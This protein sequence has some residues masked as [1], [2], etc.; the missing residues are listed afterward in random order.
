MVNLNW[1][2]VIA[3]TGGIMALYLFSRYY[4]VKDIG[5]IAAK[6]DPTDPENVIF[7]WFTRGYQAV[8]GSEETLGA[9]IYDLT[10]PAGLKLPSPATDYKPLEFTF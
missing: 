5:A 2:A 1:K 7:D 4:L 8:T 3:L 6:I 9:D 10:H